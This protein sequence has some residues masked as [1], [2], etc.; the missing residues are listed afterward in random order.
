MLDTIRKLLEQEGI[1]LTAPIL[2]EDCRLCRGYLLD[3]VGIRTG[4]AILLAVPY[5][6]HPYERQNLSVYAAVRD[7]HLYFRQLFDRLLPILR[8]RYPAHRFAGF[9]DHSPI[10]EIDAALRTGL[11]VRGDHGLLLTEA[12]SSYVF[13]GEIITNAIL[14]TS[15][16]EPGECLHCGACRRACPVA[17]D[18]TRCLSALTQKKGTLTPDEE[19]LL[20][21]HPLVWG[22]DTCQEACPYTAAAARNGTLYDTPPF[23]RAE[24][25]PYLT[26]E[27]VERMDREAFE[28]RA[29]AWRGPAVILRNLK[30]KEN[31]HT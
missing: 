19:I 8:D 23:F 20:D 12:Y 28:S 3:R 1:R 5:V 2:L 29:Y 25:L 27:Q 21:A 4:T 22:C 31:D 13:L 11:G 26:A 10:D 24:V 6:P 7:Y 15:L 14:P 17:L 9:A 30:R 18:K 16:R